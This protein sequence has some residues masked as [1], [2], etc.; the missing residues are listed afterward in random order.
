MADLPDD[1][2]ALLHE[3]AEHAA[4]IPPPTEALV[5]SVRRRRATRAAVAATASVAGVVALGLGAAAVVPAQE[6]ARVASTPTPEP[7]PSPTKDVTGT[8]GGDKYEFCDLANPDPY[9]TIAVHPTELKFAQGC[10]VVKANARQWSFT[11]PQ[12]TVHDLVIIDDNTGRRGFTPSKI[13]TT[14]PAIP[15]QEQQD[16]VMDFPL[17]AGDYS[18]TCSFH[19]EMRGQLVV[20]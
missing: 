5:R 10:Y 7:S 17:P 6:A 18:L 8:P 13:L 2:R 4:A 1:L 20:R 12:K 16:T 15:S 14:W 3:R 11:N 19:P 9:P